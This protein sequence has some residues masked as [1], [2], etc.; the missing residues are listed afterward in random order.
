MGRTN[1]V[2]EKIVLDTLNDLTDE[3]TGKRHLKDSPIARLLVSKYP[4]VF[5]DMEDARHAIGYYSGKRGR[6]NREIRGSIT[7]VEY[8]KPLDSDYSPSKIPDSHAND[9]TPYQI[10]SNIENILH[11]NDVHIPYHSKPTIEAAVKYGKE[12]QVDAIIINGDWLDCYKLSKYETDPTKRD[13]DGELEDGRQMI[14]Y[15][16]SELPNAFIYYKT[17]N[18]EERWERFLMQHPQLLKIK[19]FRLDVLLRLG[20]MRNV[21]YITNKRVIQAGDLY[22]FHGHELNNSSFAPANVSTGLFNKTL[23]HAVE[24]HHHRASVTIRKPF[25]GKVIITKSFGCMCE[26]NPAYMPI[27]EWVKGWGFTNVKSGKNLTKSI[28]YEDKRIIEI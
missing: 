25:M 22:I 8:E 5:K 15:L 14:E 18:H 28:I 3:K 13:F 23:T 21:E 12:K 16:K 2:K 6:R 11:L 7:G 20:E 27:N 26:L 24:A 4:E 10:P 9:F 17:G 19:E 1:P